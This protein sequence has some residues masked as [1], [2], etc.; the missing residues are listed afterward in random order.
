MNLDLSAYCGSFAG[1]SI[2]QALAD[3][4]PQILNVMSCY[5]MH[6]VPGPDKADPLVP[7]LFFLAVL[8]S[9][10]VA[11][12]AGFMPEGGG[13]GRTTLLSVDPQY[14][15]RGIG[16][17]LQTARLRA[18]QDLGIHPVTTNCDRQA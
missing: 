10:E 15:G 9:G 16:N 17:A 3:E 8:D 13:R 2:K 6:Q 11:G 4:L 18:M 12:A 5:N 7:E 14:G 1:F